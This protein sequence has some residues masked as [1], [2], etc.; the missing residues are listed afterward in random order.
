MI[1]P[2]KIA[3]LLSL[4]HNHYRW[5]HGRQPMFVFLEVLLM[6][7]VFASYHCTQRNNER[8]QQCVQPV[9][10]YAKI[11]NQQESANISRATQSEF[12][13]AVSLPRLGGDVFKELCRLIRD[14]DKCV[15]EYRKSCPKHITINL[16]DASYGFLCNE[17][18]D[19]FMSSAE[20]LMELDQ[21]P[22]V[23]YCHDETLADIE[24]ANHEFGITMPL[25]LDRMCEALNFFSGCVRLPIR[26]NCGVSA[27]SVI[28][29]VLRDT[30]NTLMP[31]CQ[32]T[33]QSSRRRT[34]TSHP[35]TTSTINKASSIH[36]Q[37]GHVYF[38]EDESVGERSGRIKSNPN[39]QGREKS[40]RRSEQW[41]PATQTPDVEHVYYGDRKTVERQNG[42]NAPQQYRINNSSNCSIYISF[43]VV[44]LC[45]TIDVKML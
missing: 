4:S 15:F 42:R 35:T 1:A 23:K 17:G 34:S 29:R 9:A 25:K 18:Y 16:I 40:N 2:N 13:R 14:F 36:M 26:H 33:G 27:W 44:L 30:T 24:R 7:V 38:Q 45:L 12:G 11:L 8:I 20:C 43:I 37:P 6:K 21:Q 41:N 10:Q 5:I 39:P 22:S 28:F 19:T 31:G 32:F 3:T